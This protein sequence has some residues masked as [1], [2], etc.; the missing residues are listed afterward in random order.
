MVRAKQSSLFRVDLPR[1]ANR[2]HA[3]IALSLRRIRR[4]ETR[5]LLRDGRRR[6]TN[7]PAADH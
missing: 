2:L 7:R 6:S 1:G 4:V 5:L 3:T